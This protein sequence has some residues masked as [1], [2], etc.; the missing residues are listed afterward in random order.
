MGLQRI[1][2][3]IQNPLISYVK[4]ERIFNLKNEIP[5]TFFIKILLILASHICFTEGNFYVL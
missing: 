1:Y 3:I 4:F 5:F 2:F